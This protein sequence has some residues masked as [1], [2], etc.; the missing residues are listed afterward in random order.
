[1]SSSEYEAAIQSAHAGNETAAIEK[2]TAWLHADPDNRRIMH[3]LAAVLVMVGRD[4]AALQYYER[5][6]RVDSPP[7]A[8]K[9]V[10]LAARRAGRLADAEAAYRLLLK[11]TPEDAEA[12]A[13]LAYVWMALGRTDDALAYVSGHLPRPPI[14]Y[15]RR[16]VALVVALAE[17][18]EHHKDWLLAASAYQDVLT[19]DPGFRYA[20]RG[21]VFAVNKAGLPHL[22]KRLADRQPDAFSEDERRQLA[23]DAAGRTVIFGQA[24]LEADARAARFA[25]TDVGLQA[26]HETGDRFG[27]R[28]ATLFDRLVALRDRVRMRDAVELYQHLC[29][30]G[31]TV[32]AYAKAAAADAYLY[33]EQPEIA[34]DLYREAIDEVRQGGGENVRAWQIALFYAYGEAEQHDEAQAVADGLHRDTS[35]MMNKGMRG[36]EEPNPAYSQTALLSAQARLYAGRLDQAEQRLAELRALAPHNSSIRSSWASLQSSREKP[37]AALEEFTLLRIDDPKSVDVAVGQ[38]ESLLTLN[39]FAEARAVLAPLLESSPESKAVQNFADRVDRHDRL[40]LQIDT[41]LG[42]GGSVAGAES[43]FDSR[44][45][46]APLKDSLGEPYRVFAHVSRS[47]GHTDG[48]SLART[49]IGAGIDYR[50]RDISVEAEVNQAITAP[51]A[52]GIALALSWSLS[53]AWRTSVF[54]DTNLN[55]LAAAA[56]RNGVTGKAIGASVTWI[57]NESRSAGASVSRTQF[58]D[59]NVREGVRIW[60]NERWVSGPVFKLDSS[61]GLYTSTNSLSDRVYFSPKRDKEASVAVTGEWLTWRRYQRSFTQRLTY[62]FGRYWQEGFENDAVGDLRYEHAWRDDHGIALRYGMGYGF[63]PYDG[64]RENRRYGYLNLEWQIK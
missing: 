6:A 14:A 36:I 53:D 63:H 52:N 34:R 16:D 25:T 22:A 26:N 13:G 46:S 30:A 49:R 20:L 11:K 3:D 45:Y 43:V 27:E 29:A 40:L 4:D 64:N 38:G 37:R 7:Y 9:S 12:H 21:R 42:R 50:A 62:T 39:Q 18:H 32:P 57:D 56:F 51:D 10:A 28:P 58:S 19:L 59:E 2:L 1:M 55:D 17:L 31:V 54:V 33:L 15:T 61:V 41:T 60:W 35:P 5:I 47:Q 8:I 44:L 48:S 24:Q 23:H